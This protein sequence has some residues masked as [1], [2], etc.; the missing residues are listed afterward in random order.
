MTELDNDCILSILSVGGAVNQS[1][2][3]WHGFEIVQFG[4]S[5]HF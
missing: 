1:H 4:N 5:C 3:Q 2:Q